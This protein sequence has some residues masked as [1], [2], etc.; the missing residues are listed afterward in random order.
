MR[1]LSSTSFLRCLA[2][3]ATAAT[4]AM[5]LAACQPAQERLKTRLPT[6]NPHPVERYKV[7]VEVT[8]APGEFQSAEGFVLFQ[9]TGETRSCVPNLASGAKAAADSGLKMPF[10]LSKT[11]PTT[12][13]GEVVL[14]QFVPHDDY[15]LGPCDWQA[16]G[17]N[18]DLWNGVN[19]HRG[20]VFL[21][22]T[23]GAFA[24]GAENYRIADGLY[25]G[26]RAFLLSVWD[27]DRL[28]PDDPPPKP[29]DPPPS[30]SGGHSDARHLIDPAR[31]ATR[32]YITVTAQRMDP[33][34]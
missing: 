31:L 12:F 15:G 21:A 32:Y 24:K 29:G 14:D 26:R 4:L 5:L 9:I 27:N 19:R 8:N 11:S 1:R 22:P 33:S 30:F 7:T 3:A 28:L 13:E 25:R 10:A 18:A 17:L 23:G 34:P 20:F 2:A 16:F 6:P